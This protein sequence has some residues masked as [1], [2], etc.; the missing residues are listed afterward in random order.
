MTSDHYLGLWLSLCEIK[1]NNFWFT[2]L[3]QETMPMQGRFL[4][5][6]I[7]LNAIIKLCLYFLNGDNENKLRLRPSVVWSPQIS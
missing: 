5:N 4:S 7:T 1:R 6:D 2:A 3:H